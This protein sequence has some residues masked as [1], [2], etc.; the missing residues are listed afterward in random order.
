MADKTPLAGSPDLASYRWIAMSSSGGKDSQA[1]LDILVKR[2]MEA[3][4]P[5]DRIV[6]IFADLGPEDEWEGTEELAR[7]H[8]AHYGLRFEV[9]RRMVKNAEG[10]EVPQTLSEYIEAHGKFPGFG[11]RFCTAGMKRDPITKF[12]TVLAREARE[13]DGVRTGQVRILSVMGLRAEESAKRAK[14][15]PFNRDNRASG[16]GKSKEV[17]EW[18]PIHHMT[19]AQVWFQIKL[20]GTR[21]HP[22]YAEGMPRLSC[23]FCPLASKSAL[24]RAA[25]LRPALAWKKAEMEDRMGHTIGDGHYS[26]L[27]IIEAAETA[28][29][30][31]AVAGWEA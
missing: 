12:F 9:V 21:S 8:A 15:Q 4:V 18:L 29:E 1:A 14:M 11:T 27:D 22:A 30:P 23:V 19:V 31:V 5:L 7:E 24:V 17:H 13:Q 3:G 28:P 20:A 26:M 25:Q 6:V 10:V 16:E 2:C